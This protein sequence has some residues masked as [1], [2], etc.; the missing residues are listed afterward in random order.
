MRIDCQMVS[1]PSLDNISVFKKILNRFFSLNIATKVMLG[2][3]FLSLLLIVVSV[4]ALSNLKRL[5]SINESIIKTDV[6]LIDASDKM[7][8]NLLAQELYG[9]RYAILKSSDMLVLFW[10]RSE[11]FDQ[12]AE[13][14]PHLPGQ[15]NFPLDKLTALHNE[16]N[17][18]FLKS[19][20]SARKSSF[21]SDAQSASLKK[22]EEELIG[23]IKK[24]SADA[25]QNQKA[26]AM[27]TSAIGKNAFRITA[28]LCLLGLLFGVGSALII[29]KNI[30]GSISQLKFATK[31][32][33]EGRFDYKNN[34]RN[35]D[36]LGELSHAFGEMAM[37]LK[38][39]EEMY[40][41]AS[42][43]TRLP[44]GIAIE[45]ILQKRLDAGTP[46]AFCMLDLDNFKSFNDHYGYAMGSEVIKATA[47][48]I[49]EV[50][51]RKGTEGDFVGHIG[52]DDFVVIS[53]LEGY[54]NICK[55]IIEAFDK[56]IL[57]FYST[58]DRTTGYIMGK[59]RQGQEVSF[60]I[61]TISIAVVTNKDRKFTNIAEV[62][63]IAAELKDYAKSIPGSIY[64]VDK[65]R[66]VLSD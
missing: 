1:V 11:E 34:V 55:G 15:S 38:R 41:D 53:T 56:T 18:A 49:E 5:N 32:I 6:P 27:M 19:V 21:I 24:I 28:S 23:F 62:G 14:I 63:E 47:R 7:I 30:S 35:K 26:K 33:S 9:R 51:S 17:S 36:E 39:L 25:H 48:I 4:F 12:I 8:D 3:G 43:L 42:P 29:T 37:R 65:R 57:D 22:K 2:Y 16:Y 60:P 45:N 50:V 20:Q 64:V 40:L 61:M 52:G 66:K 58:E 44:G 13:Q 31:Q 10:N 46:L 59:T 54:G